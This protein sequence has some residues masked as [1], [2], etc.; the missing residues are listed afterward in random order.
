MRVCL[1]VAGCAWT[2]AKAVRPWLWGRAFQVV[3]VVEDACDVVA[4][5]RLGLGISILRLSC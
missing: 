4:E 3:P 1:M 2:G 5:N